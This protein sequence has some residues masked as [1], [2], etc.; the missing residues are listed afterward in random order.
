MSQAIFVETIVLVMILA[1]FLGGLVNYFLV[2]RDDPESS[3]WKSITLGT[4]ASLLVPLFLN[5]ISSGLLESIR[6][7]ASGTPD[8][9]KLLVFSGFCLVAAI[10]S[11]AFIKTLSDRVL[12]EAKEAKKV[13]RQADQ[14][15]SEVQSAIQPI[16]DK[17]T[18]V[19]PPSDASKAVA[20]SAPPTAE[21]E[22]KLLQNLANG[23]WVLRTRTGL[24]K[25]TGIAKSD[26][27]RMMDDLRKRQLV[28]YRWIVSRLSDKRK[29]W[30][31]TN[32]GRE[33]IASG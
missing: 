29:R 28:D 33:A 4:A 21:N 15:A 18:E 10:S 3:F 6:N 2:R 7:G 19:D 12:Q 11:T 9:S 27:D 22:R 23:K 1:G 20:A 30:Y 26:V 25:E 5:M 13:A 14:K 8:L 32:R 16:V 24:A 17:E 31:I